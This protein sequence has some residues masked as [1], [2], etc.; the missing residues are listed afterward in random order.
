MST[1]PVHAALG[2]TVENV[3][4]ALLAIGEDQWFDRKSS[5]IAA[6]SLAE[7][8]CGMANADG[9]VI[10]VGLHDGAVEG[11]DRR[12]T[13]RNGQMQAGVDF[14]VPPVHVKTELIRCINADGVEDHLLVIAVETSD[15]VHATTK[16]EVFLR[17]GDETRRLGFHQR[18]ELTYDKGQAS[19]E[20][21]VLPEVGLPDVDVELLADYAA[22]IGSSD[23]LQVLRARGLAVDDRLT[24]AGALLFARNPQRALPESFVRVLR[25]RGRE[26]GSGARQQLLHD[27]RLE[28][29]IPWILG[30]AQATIE[31]LQPKRRALQA[32]GR[33]GEVPLIP[34]DAWLEGLVNAVVH[35]SYSAG[36]DHIRV[37]IFDDRLEISSPGRFPGLV[38]LRN[39][40]AT[41]RFARNP[42]IARVC[43]DLH[44]GQELGEGVR[45]IF[46]EM[47][48]AGLVD[49]SYRQTSGS[50]ELTLLAEPVDRELEARL[51]GHARAITSALRE[52]GRLSTGEVVDL[53]E[54]SR[55]VVQR[56]LAALREAGV[57]EWV[58]KSP[59]DP[60]A[61]WRIAPPT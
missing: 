5:K 19:F 20:S 7:A 16:D 25:Y 50:V 3:G 47:R 17:I 56:E 11:T 1:V 55:P 43:S 15:V 60:R 35:R 39:P 8:L 27:E 30:A 46:D 53:L 44:F 23:G 29:P 24:V 48:Q 51:P 18:Q 13:Q 9:G 2:E 6:R 38:D 12:I 36:G 49:P 32:N 10:V 42:R 26:R 45:R 58:G 37:E 22:A 40:E 59:R 61:F 4:P 28:G 34:P 57:I 14:C 21:R 54:L 33:F 52:A 41:L 31:E